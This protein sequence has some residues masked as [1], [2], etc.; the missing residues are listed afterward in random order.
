MLWEWYFWFI[1]HFPFFYSFVV[2]FIIPGFGGW[3]LFLRA[4]LVSTWDY[5]YDLV[6]PCLELKKNDDDLPVMNSYNSL[7]YWLPSNTSTS[8][9]IILLV[10]RQAYK[11][12]RYKKL[13]DSIDIGKLY[14]MSTL[15]SK[16]CLYTY[17]RDT[18]ETCLR[19]IRNNDEGDWL[20]D[21]A[22]TCRWR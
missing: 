14:G 3:G 7:W 18:G 21:M 6:I 2:G 12:E 9:S 19:V 11:W 5:I 22:P 13:R 10:K 15:G 1:F 20:E 17:D 4:A 8:S 16:G